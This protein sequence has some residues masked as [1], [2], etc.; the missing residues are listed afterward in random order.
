MHNTAKGSGFGYIMKKIQIR[1]IVPE[2]HARVVAVVN[3]WWGGRDMVCM[4]PRLFFSHFRNT[5][6]VVEKDSELVGFLVG[7]L[8]QSEA[9]EAY[10]HFAGIHPEHRKQGVAMELYNRFFDTVKNKSCR[11]VRCITSPVNKASIAFHQ[12]LGFEFDGGDCEIDGVPVV[13]NYDGAGNPRVLFRK[14][15]V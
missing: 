1:H 12:H 9:G 6:F 11:V 7:F 10:I 4:L 2:D 3:E 14:M 5:S 8:S 15:L 13:Q